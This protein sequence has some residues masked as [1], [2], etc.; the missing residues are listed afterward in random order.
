[1]THASSGCNHITNRLDGC[2]LSR[3]DL[4]V[5]RTDQQDRA[6]AAIRLA[7]DAS[8]AASKRWIVTAA[9]SQGLADV[10]VCR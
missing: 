7:A 1:M 9:S 10:R 3:A 6:A 4:G 8:H 5:T 2:A